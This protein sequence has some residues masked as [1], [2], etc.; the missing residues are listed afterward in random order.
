M[1]SSALGLLYQVPLMLVIVSAVPHLLGLP[2]VVPV[3][4]SLGRG[5]ESG[6]VTLSGDGR[7]QH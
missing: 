5:K 6:P 2:L 3:T 1:S 7:P 4:R